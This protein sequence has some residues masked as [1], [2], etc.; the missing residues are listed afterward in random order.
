MELLTRDAID[1]TIQQ[2]SQ[3]NGGR[4]VALHL[5]QA[6]VHGFNLYL[7]VLNVA[8]DDGIYRF[9]T[10]LR[11][12]VASYFGGDF[13]QAQAK[14]NMINAAHGLSMDEVREIV[15]DTMFPAR[16]AAE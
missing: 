1:E 11:N 12:S 6:M 13:E 8:G 14:V 16:R 9:P 3:M 2:L 7:P 15:L 4:P 10:F 5:D